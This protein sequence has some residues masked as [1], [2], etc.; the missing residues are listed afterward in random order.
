MPD[1]DELVIQIDSN[2]KSAVSGIE[3]LATS[4][5][6]LK[7]ATSGG[8]GL[9][10]VAKQMVSLKTSLS[11]MGNLGSKLS[12]LSSAINTLQKLGS[13]KISS[14]I[15]N[16]VTKIGTAL[17]TLDI[18]DGASKIQGVVEAL[19]P[20][21]TLGKSSI[22]TTVNSLKK[23]PEALNKIDMRKLHGQVDALTRT[24]R[25]LA[26]EMQKIANGFNAFPNRIQKLIK[27]NE[28]L[29]ASNEKTGKSYINLW[30]KMRMAYTSVKTG[31]RTIGG[32][33]NKSA[34]YNE[35]VNRFSVSLGKYA[36]AHGKD[37]EKISELM[38]I[39]PADW[40]GSEATFMALSSGF[41]I[42]GDRAAL[43][44]QQLTQLG[45]DISSFHDL[46]V[47]DAMLKLQSGLAGELEPLRRIGYDLS[48]ARLQQEAYTLGI[49]KKVSAMTQAEKAELRYYTIMK[50]STLAMGDMA[51]TIEDP[52]NQLRIFKA[53]VNQAARSLGNMFIP[54][55][56]AVLPVATAVVK[57]IRLV[58]DIIAGLFGY[59]LPEIEWKGVNSLASGAEQASDAF[60]TATDNAKKLKQY[61]MGFDELNVIDPNKGSSDSG[62]GVGT[63]G[64]FGFEL[65]T[66]DFLGDLQE[67]KV[68]TIVESMKEWLGITK[69]IKTWSDLLETRLGKIL[70]VVGLIGA[71]FLTWKV[72][73]GIVGVVT[74]IAGLFSKIGGLFG[75]GKKSSG[76]GTG[77]IGAGDTIET[78]SQ[79]MSQTTSKLKTLVKNL[80][81]GIAVIAEVVVA[82]ALIVGG[83]W[84]LGWE[85][86][87]VGKAWQPVIDNAGTVTIAMVTGTA[88]LVGIGFATASLGTLGGAMCG[89]MGIGIAILAELGVAT[90]LFLAE[91]W[92]IGLLLVEIG[93]AWQ[94]V[95]DNG[96][97]ITKG[98]TRGT[99]LLV[100]IGVVTALLGTATVASAGA[101]PIAIGLGTAILLELGLAFKLF[102]DSLIDVA[103]KLADDLHPS[104]KDLNRILPD[105]NDNMEDF[106]EFMVDFAEMTVDYTK[107]SAISGFSATIDSIIGFFTKDPI[108][109]LADDV[110]KQYKHS[111][112]LN[113]KL[114]LANPELQK[115]IT[116]LGTYKSRVDSLKSVA[117]TISVSDMTTTVFTNLVTVGEKIA[118]FGGEMK[119]Y[120]NKIKDISVTT[121]DKMVNCVND[122]IDFAVRIKDE[123]DT[124]A[125]DKFTTSLKDLT[126]AIKDMPTSKTLTIK[127]IYQATG[128]TP[129]QYATGGFPSTG[130][131]FVAR[132]AGPELVG[133]IGR[134]TAV[135]NND[136]I[137]EGIAYGVSV[138]NRE[139]DAL[140]RE[141]NLLLRAM[142]EKESGV[143]IDGK[144]VSKSVEKHQRERGRVLVTG[145][146][147]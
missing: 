41:G 14:S 33:I 26:E 146:A 3:A 125:I 110:N 68:S 84:L 27:E 107:S 25:P 72:V 49:N 133:N 11:G 147:Y 130:E 32:L 74:T 48:V 38:G 139:S 31:A 126:K 62:S 58:A 86:E 45:Y 144:S 121:M 5:G 82:A 132:E 109:A 59:E 46:S 112:I 137:V 52:A 97:T 114:G 18:G 76:S 129:K 108:K 69:E 89:Q 2:S 124:K 8:L 111:V 20:L 36:E 15:S 43:M 10:S 19:K 71:G 90:G 140:L 40:L 55:L 119:A 67:S 91:I 85:L 4:L 83:I 65:P 63:G 80:A 37:A 6:K 122:V 105:L 44:S 7:S 24:F 102:C 79:N 42:A 77:D 143:Y 17:S 54:A 92:G 142:L 60:G 120:Y 128:T 103:D 50:Q 115:A 61:T 136:Q 106:T 104:L 51:R 70:V 39:D 98:I 94:P 127:A 1:I 22:T 16:Q 135:A 28:K 53:Q 96:K 113:E 56:M 100:G 64:G 75:G 12:G 87:Q 123:V 9:N 117:D 23:L 95:L 134:R 101:L 118:D 99:G 57:V 88:L 116:G 131:L 78:A 47:E 145:G 35:T 13:V 30:A 66:Y 34:E 73:A 93:K 81:L 21:E 138:A 141:Q 29:S